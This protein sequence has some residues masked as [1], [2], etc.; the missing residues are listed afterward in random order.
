[1]KH[2]KIYWL[3]IC[4]ALVLL[5]LF[6]WLDWDESK[7]QVKTDFADSH[8]KLA[9]SHNKLEEIKSLQLKAIN[10]RMEA[11]GDRDKIMEADALIEEALALDPANPATLAGKFAIYQLLDQYDKGL[12]VIKKMI[13]SQPEAVVHR[14]SLCMVRERLGAPHDQCV[15]CYRSVVSWCDKRCDKNDLNYLALCLL[16]EMP[17]AHEKT[18]EHFKTFGYDPAI[19]EMYEGIFINFDRNDY[20]RAT[21]PRPGEKNPYN[22]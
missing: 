18:M 21:L 19:R 22:K 20:I 15:A 2:L 12:E 1:M 9:D 13:E 17:G 6:A 7:P 4:V 5:G 8:D 3:A 11:N 14:V 10:I 16:A